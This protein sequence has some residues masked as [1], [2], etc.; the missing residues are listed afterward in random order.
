MVLAG[1]KCD[2][3]EKL[4]YVSKFVPKIDNF[5]SS[6][7]A[8]YI[9]IP[10]I[11]KKQKGTTTKLYFIQI[12]LP[13]NPLSIKI[14]ITYIIKF[15]RYSD[16][17]QRQDQRRIFNQALCDWDRSELFYLAG[18]G[19]CTADQSWERNAIPRHSPVDFIS[20]P[21]LISAPRNFSKENTG[22]L[23]AI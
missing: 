21:R 18:Y 2:F 19:K 4:N 7:I 6:N 16:T 20:G 10:F 11:S 14:L 9:I 1:A 23:I 17:G 3:E 5:I 22:I 13:R 8:V 12:P 15:G